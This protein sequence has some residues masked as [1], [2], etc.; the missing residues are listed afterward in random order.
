MSEAVGGEAGPGRR[1]RRAVVLVT[2]LATALAAALVSGVSGARYV[3]NDPR[4]CTATC[5]TAAAGEHHLETPGH[6]EIACQKCHPANA[7][8]G[9]RLLWRSML[10][11]VQGGPAHI[12]NDPGA[13]TSCHSADVTQWRR[14]TDTAGHHEHMAGRK[15]VPCL[16]CHDE[17]MHKQPKPDA[18]CIK[19]HKAA[20]LHAKTPDADTCLSCHNFSSKDNG[21]HGLTLTQC[22]KCHGKDAKKNDSGKTVTATVVSGDKLHG[23]VNCRLCHQ[24]H[25][26]R[27]VLA[28]Q[29]CNDCHEIQIGTE[30]SPAPEGHRVCSKCHAPHAPLSEAAVTCAQ[31]H[32]QAKTRTAGERST[33]LRHDSCSSCHVP[34]RWIPERSGCARCH[35]ENAQKILTKSPEKHQTCTACHEVHGPVPS[36]ATCVSCHKARRS[37]LVSAPAR[38]KNCASCHDPH[39]AKESPVK[40]CPKCHTN[41][42]KQMMKDGPAQ[43][44][45]AGC[46]KCHRP[47]NNPL[48]DPKACNGCHS[49]KAKLVSAA[50]PPKHKECASC[51]APHT[52]KVT[53]SKTACGRCHQGIA[54]KPGNHTGDC[55]KCHNQHGS[56]VVSRAACVGCHEK[57]DL[58]PPPGNAPHANCGSCH[59]PHLAAKAALGQCRSCHQ[60][61]A[62]VAKLWPAGSAHAG[63][64]NKCHQPHAVRT[65]ETCASCHD[66]QAATGAGGKHRCQQC[67]APHETPASSKAGWWNRCSKCHSQQLAD[68]KVGKH[69]MACSK[70]HEQHRFARPNCTT[71]HKAIHKQAAHAVKEHRQCSKCHDEHKTTKPGRNECLSCHTDRREHEPQAKQCYACHPFK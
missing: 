38:H 17:D 31:C 55:K 12:G 16:S 32:D 15:P 11:K 71:C 28:R 35:A 47:H 9:F 27:S 5:H 4:M 13:C 3:R 8:V 34:H 20:K 62:Q 37:H 66:K 36:G 6:E 42:L 65:I 33:A 18:S 26:E 21:V 64:C 49:D 22:D 53:S 51:H 2:V 14:L 24:P 69:N 7:G 44:A 23:K 46:F 43:H 48:P 54:A 58:R 57:I 59:K 45:E 40:A 19:C 25:R 30:A 50:G 10:G 61:K 39:A 29:P 41:E 63:E 56:P 60:D 70:C 52:F 1:R 68:T 67:H